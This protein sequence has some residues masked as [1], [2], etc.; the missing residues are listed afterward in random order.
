MIEAENATAPDPDE[1]AA[2]AIGRSLLKARRV[3]S[4]AIA[5]AEQRAREFVVTPDLQGA[6]VTS[7]VHVT[8]PISR[9][10]GSQPAPLDLRALA[11]QVDEIEEA[12]L[13][14][15][16]RILRLLNEVPSS[17]PVSPRSVDPFVAPS[18][19]QAK[20]SDDANVVAAPEPEPAP[21]SPPTFRPV[22]THSNGVSSNLSVWAPP[23][24]ARRVTIPADEPADDQDVA[25]EQQAMQ[26][27]PVTW[28]A[29]EEPL[30]TSDQSQPATWPS[31][32]AGPAAAQPYAR[33]AEPAN[34]SST[35]WLLNVIGFSVLLIVVVVVLMLANVL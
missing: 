15:H 28:P 34:G 2:L 27:A 23:D 6:G 19:A 7:G 10:P 20:A 5:E 12:L 25:P 13:S 16:R 35:L 3:A 30:P 33:P 1:A 17:E 8:P 14:G 22:T 18:D 21:P 31:E 24:A 11:A 32:A 9:L 26:E 29:P 4:E